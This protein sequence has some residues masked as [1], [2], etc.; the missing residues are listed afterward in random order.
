MTPVTFVVRR[1]PRTALEVAAYGAEPYWTSIVST[2]VE[3][4]HSHV[5]GPRAAAA[6]FSTEGDARFVARAVTLYDE[7]STEVVVEAWDDAEASTALVEEAALVRYVNALDAMSVWRGHKV[8]TPMHLDVE[9]EHRESLAAIERLGRAAIK[10]GLRTT[11]GES[12]D[13]G[14]A[15]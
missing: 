3:H 6:R 12:A 8:K 4:E 5:W 13:D 9:R 1:V 7:P 15:R 10:R 11:T 2:T 14:R